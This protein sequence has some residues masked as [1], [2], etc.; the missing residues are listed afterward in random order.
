M[1]VNETGRGDILRD[2][3]GL[4]RERI[5]ICPDEES[6]KIHRKTNIQGPMEFLPGPNVHI[7]LFKNI[8]VNILVQGLVISGALSITQLW[9]YTHAPEGVPSHKMSVIVQLKIHDLHTDPWNSY[10]F[11]D[12]A[13]VFPSK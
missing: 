6:T 7:H 12:T 3:E 13:K 1:H 4:R 10:T 8:A 2:E 9:R 11:D 5:K